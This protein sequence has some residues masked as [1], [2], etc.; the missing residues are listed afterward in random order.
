MI[1]ALNKQIQEE[2]F[3]AYL[4]QSMSA[5]FASENLSGI[6]NWFSV[7]AKEEM[8]HAFKIYDFIIERGGKVK[9]LAVNE[10]QDLWDS[11]QKAFEDALEHEKHIT[12]CFDKLMDQA[13]EE[14]DHAT[15]IFLE[16][17]VTEQIEEEA[18]AS[19]IVEKIKM[20]GNHGHGLVMLDKEL[21]QRVFVS[22]LAQE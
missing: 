11:A 9:L 14:K 16:W 19:E 18:S 10:P 15:R 13:M 8:T 7:Q 4:Y 1:K 6:A 21:G 12:G 2:F 17:F 5:H 20:S 22:S 3:S